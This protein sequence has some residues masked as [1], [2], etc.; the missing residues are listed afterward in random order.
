MTKFGVVFLVVLLGSALA[1][2]AVP[3]RGRSLLH[4]DGGVIANE[5]L[6]A[7]AGA[8]LFALLAAVALTTLSMPGFLPEH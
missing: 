5:R 8:V 7:L 2:A 4:L 1:A 3:A 6:T